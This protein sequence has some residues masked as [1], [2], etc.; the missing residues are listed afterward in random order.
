MNPTRTRILKTGALALAAGLT[1][2]ACGG[3]SAERHVVGHDGQSRRDLGLLGV[4]GPAGH[5]QPD[6]QRRHGQTPGD[7]LGPRREQRRPRHWPGRR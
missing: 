3:S 4:P 7:R 6:H 2:A 5:R 1:L